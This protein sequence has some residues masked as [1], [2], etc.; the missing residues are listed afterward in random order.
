[1]LS[2]SMILREVLCFGRVVRANNPTRDILL[3][4]AMIVAR[5]ARFIHWYCR[6]TIPTVIGRQSRAV[7]F[8]I[9][10]DGV[11]YGF[12]ASDVKLLL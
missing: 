4:M 10:R 5:M 8:G 6:L 3:M 9:V 7:S 1:M 2:E 12:P 11:D